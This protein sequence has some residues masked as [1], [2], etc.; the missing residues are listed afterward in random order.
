[1]LGSTHATPGR[2]TPAEASWAGVARPSHADRARSVRAVVVARKMLPPPIAE[3]VIE[4]IAWDIDKT[5]ALVD[6]GRAIAL[7]TAV[8]SLDQP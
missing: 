4:Q 8:L 6:R 3:L 2:V 1:M 5:A 7:V